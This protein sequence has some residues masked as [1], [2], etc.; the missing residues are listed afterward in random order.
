[1]IILSQLSKIIYNK[2]LQLRIYIFLS[3]CKKVGK[4]IR[5]AF[6]L[7]FEG[8]HEIEIGNY[9]SIASFVHIW[10]HGGVKIGN[11]VLIATYTAITS[12]THDYTYETIRFAPIIAKPVVIGDDVW[13]GSNAV[14]NPGVTIGVTGK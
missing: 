4:S 11:R 6:P 9:V 13:I 8:K 1:M 3:V 10:G 2:F 12:L 7:T 14:I 5:L